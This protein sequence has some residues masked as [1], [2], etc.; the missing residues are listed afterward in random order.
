MQKRF[1]FR[2]DAPSKHITYLFYICVLISSLLPR[3]YQRYLLYEERKERSGSGKYYH[4]PQRKVHG[5]FVRTS[6]N[7]AGDGVELIYVAER[8]ADSADNLQRKRVKMTMNGTT[9]YAPPPH[10][11]QIN[12][13]GVI[14]GEYLG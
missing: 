11:H 8:L 2:C 9:G 1:Y 5:F 13:G 3:S 14:F 7:G 12:V 4:K 10:R 6:H